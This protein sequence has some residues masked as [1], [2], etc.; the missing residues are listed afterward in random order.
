MLSIKTD[1]S[2]TDKGKNQESIKLINDYLKTVIRETKNFKSDRKVRYDALA[3]LDEMK[4]EGKLKQINPEDIEQTQN[5]IREKKNEHGVRSWLNYHNRGLVQDYVHDT[6]DLLSDKTVPFEE[7]VATSAKVLLGIGIASV[8][9]GG[10]AQAI[11]GEAN[12][13]KFMGAS[14]ERLVSDF[15]MGNDHYQSLVPVVAGVAA[16]AMTAK[17]GVSVITKPK[18]Q[19]EAKKFEEYIDIKHS[20][21]ALKQL[22][23]FLKAEPAVSNEKSSLNKKSVL[24]QAVLKKNTLSY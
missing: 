4:A 18:S 12:Y 16:A 21:I 10:V 13:D 8:A 1:T 23:K 19:E 6:V 2:E 20:Q 7:K 24:S 17:I 3:V 5:R 11:L 9:T 22:K 15:M 14:D